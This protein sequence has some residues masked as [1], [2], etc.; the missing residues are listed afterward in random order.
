MSQDESPAQAEPESGAERAQEPYHS[1]LVQVPPWASPEPVCTP[2]GWQGPDDAPIW[3]RTRA[4][5]PLK[6]V[7]IEELEAML[8][9]DFL[10]SDHDDDE[11]YQ[12]FL[13]VKSH[14]LPLSSES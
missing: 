13:R 8:Q 14:D 1:E 3:Q 2:E 4:R 11:A 7:S 10:E 9:E 6:D 5:N 12:D